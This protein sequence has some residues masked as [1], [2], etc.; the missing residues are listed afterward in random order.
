MPRDGFD[1]GFDGLDGL[2]TA[3]LGRDEGDGLRRRVFKP[4]VA[5]KLV[6]C[7]ADDLLVE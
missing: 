3:A 2:G 5:F 7:D 4:P 1:G 6:S